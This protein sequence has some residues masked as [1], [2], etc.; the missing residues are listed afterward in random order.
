MQTVRVSSRDHNFSEWFRS[1]ACKPDYI[2]ESLIS[3]NIELKMEESSLKKKGAKYGM[4]T[5]RIR[6]IRPIADTS[7]EL[8]VD[9]DLASKKRDNEKEEL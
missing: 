6:G 7:V 8:S 5:M 2:Y 4:K 1:D 3:A 9:A